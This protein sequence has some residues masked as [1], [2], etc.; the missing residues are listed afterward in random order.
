M[1]ASLRRRVA[2][3]A[4]T[5]LAAT[6][7]AAP[8]RAQPG[9]DERTTVQSFTVEHVHITSRRPFD[10]VKASLEARL[11]SVDRERMA[12]SIRKG[13]L[14]GARRKRRPKAIAYGTG[15]V[16][17]ANSM[18][19]RNL[20]AD[21]YAPIRVELYEGADGTAVF[22][23]DQPSSTFRMFSDPEIDKVASRLDKM[24]RDVLLEVSR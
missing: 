9:Q 20:A 19:R 18:T 4:A 7:L 24:L 12:Q 21:L 13:D 11:R 10:E 1:H 6:A 15:N 17:I 3:T 5:Q 8:T 14:A 16:L 22:E 2:L 23:Y